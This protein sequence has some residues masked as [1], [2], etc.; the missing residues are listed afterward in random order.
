MGK[1][2]ELIILLAEELEDLLW[3]TGNFEDA[4]RNLK[5]QLSSD[6]WEFYLENKD[7]IIDTLEFSPLQPEER[8]KLDHNSYKNLD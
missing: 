2:K 6:E 1:V 4:E 5:H 8:K 3:H 7:Y